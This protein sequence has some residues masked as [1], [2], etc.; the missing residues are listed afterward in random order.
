MKKGENVGITMALKKFIC[1]YTNIPVIVN[2][3]AYIFI[4]WF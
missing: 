2:M 3:S 4:E 1:Q